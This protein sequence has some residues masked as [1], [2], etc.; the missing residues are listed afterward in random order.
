MPKKKTKKIK[1]SVEHEPKVASRI[2]FL[3]AAIKLSKRYVTGDGSE[4]DIFFTNQTKNLE[5]EL[6]DI[7]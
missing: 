3:E 7:K 5:K 1:K 4:I 2:R 6:A